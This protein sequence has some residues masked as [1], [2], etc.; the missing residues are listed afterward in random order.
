MEVFCFRR[1]YQ[2]KKVTC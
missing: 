1:L 2:N